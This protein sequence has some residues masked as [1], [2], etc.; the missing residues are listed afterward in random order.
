[1][2]AAK[3]EQQEQFRRNERKWTKPLMDAGYTVIPY[4][5]LDRQDSFGLSPVEVNVLLHLANHWWHPD[6]LPRPTK[7]SLAKRMDVSEKTVQRAI[8][9]MEE[10]GL[11]H[12]I[13]RHKPG[14]GQGANF[15]EFTGL[16]EKALPFAQEEI[17]RRTERQVEDATRGGRKKALRL[18]KNEETE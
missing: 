6:N 18:V 2:K 12:R 15:Y 13:K 4:V 1:M 8:A 7:A 14:G 17:A 16:I 9:H 3:T 5:I 11:I 10:M